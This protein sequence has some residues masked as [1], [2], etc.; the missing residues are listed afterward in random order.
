MVP[1][2]VSLKVWYS[3]VSSTAI[4][5]FDAILQLLTDDSFGMSTLTNNRKRGLDRCNKANKIS[6]RI[7]ARLIFI[8][9]RRQLGLILSTARQI[10]DLSDKE[11]EP[12]GTSGKI[13]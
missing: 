3:S 4:D 11:T 1:K 7:K 6:V 10:S 2:N 9:W 13:L 5:I 8:S 12:E